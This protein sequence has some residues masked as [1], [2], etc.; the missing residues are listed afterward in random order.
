MIT[1]RSSLP[2][3][4]SG[5][6]PGS[7]F[8]WAVKAGLL[9][10]AQSTPDNLVLPPPLE[11]PLHVCWAVAF[12][13]AVAGRRPCPWLRWCRVIRPDALPVLSGTVCLLLGV[14]V[15][16]FLPPKVQRWDV[17]SWLET[18]S[19]LLPW[20]PVTDQ[21]PGHSSIWE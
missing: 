20:S 5:T 1:F 9:A 14:I 4:W 3:P 2:S 19:Y 8:T 17:G 10:D 13:C 7:L 21:Y 11:P 6:F 15:S 18:G 12:Q 16:L